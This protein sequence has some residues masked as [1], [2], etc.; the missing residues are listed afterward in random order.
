MARV[1]DILARQ[2]ETVVTIG[3]ESQLRTQP[4]S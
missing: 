3:V 2:G 1:K 4:A